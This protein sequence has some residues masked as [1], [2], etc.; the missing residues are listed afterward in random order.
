MDV[1]GEKIV[2]CDKIVYYVEI[3]ICGGGGG[4]RR[5]T[6]VVAVGVGW[7]W[8]RI[9]SALKPGGIAAVAKQRA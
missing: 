6:A 9:L 2:E 1:A 8:F 3:T 5:N 4:G 7:R